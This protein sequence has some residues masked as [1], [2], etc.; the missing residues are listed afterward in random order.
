MVSSKKVLKFAAF[1]SVVL[2]ALWFRTYFHAT[3]FWDHPIRAD[4]GQYYSIGWNLV[5]HGV[6]SMTFPS[7]EVPTPDSY[8]GPGYPLLVA[9]SMLIGGEDNWYRHLLFWQA[10]MGALSA[11]LT[12]AI[13]RY[14]LT[15]PYVIAAGLLM[16]VWPHTVTLSG[17]VLTET[18]FGVTTLLGIYVLGAAL[19]RNHVFLF[20]LSGLVFGYAAL[21][22][23]MILLFPI[24]I[25]TL[26]LAFHRKYAVL[27]LVCALVL[28][29][30]WAMR[31]ASLESGRSSSERLMENVLA[32]MEPEWDYTHTPAVK[33]ARARLASGIETYKQDPSEVVELIFTRIMTDPALYAKWY[34]IGKPLRFWQW[35]MLGEGDIYVYTPI[36][37]TFQIHPLYRGIASLCASLN[38]WLTGAS[39]LYVLTFVVTQGRQGAGKREAHLTLVVAIF[40]YATALHTALT[41]DPRYA[42][43]FRPYEIMLALSFVALVLDHLKKSR[44]RDSEN[45]HSTP[46]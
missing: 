39:F 6:Y 42:T 14:W 34:F 18:F 33:E 5:H 41:P 7:D 44:Q 9:L 3:T 19:K 10:L 16:A 25:S 46:A 32:G 31:G 45:K 38:P 17:L 4:A 1:A 30:S 12:M 11:G 37:T 28:P 20:V 26:L 27:F 43:P 2:F 23:P 21:I 29:T 8:R 13:A 24:L 22:N 15:F 35:S 40:V 36:A